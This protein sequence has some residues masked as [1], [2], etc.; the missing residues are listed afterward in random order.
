MLG[1]DTCATGSPSQKN[2]R[3]AARSSPLHRR[4]RGRENSSLVCQPR[5]VRACRT[6]GARP[7]RGYSIQSTD[8]WCRNYSPRAVEYL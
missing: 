6:T 4:V 8:E 2:R 1:A 5:M 3:V 7:L